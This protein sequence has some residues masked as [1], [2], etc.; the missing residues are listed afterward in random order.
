MSYNLVKNFNTV[1]PQEDKVM[2]DSNEIIAQK[3]QIYRETHPVNS[4]PGGFQ[5]GLSARQIDV[6]EN[7]DGLPREEGETDIPMEDF[8]ASSFDAP[9]YEGPDPR[10]LV[11]QAEEEIEKMKEEARAEIEE[12]RERAIEDGRKKGYDAGYDQGNKEGMQ[13]LDRE[14][15]ELSEERVKMAEEYEQMVADLEPDLVETINDIYKYIFNVDMSSYKDIVSYLVI[16]SLNHIEASKNYLIHVAKEDY[17]YISMQKKLIQAD[18]IVGSASLE[19]VED[20]SLA[21]GQCLI[22]TESGIYDC[23]LDTQ[24]TELSKKLKILSYQKE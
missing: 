6:V 14:R 21:K 20:A 24:L 4:N 10:E 5:A 7:E 3:L 11:A 12:E 19:F 18:S 8:D 16:N 23:G 15:R 22:E 17:A 1:I 13:R 2:I 9:V